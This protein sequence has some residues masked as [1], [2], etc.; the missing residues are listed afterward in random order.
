MI[1]DITDGIRTELMEAQQRHL[2]SFYNLLYLEAMH[3]LVREYRTLVNKCVYSADAV[4]VEGRRDVLGT[5][6]SGSESS[7]E[8]GMVLEDLRRRG[9]E[10]I[11]IVSVDGLSGF[12]ETIEAVYPETIV[13][14]C[15]V[16]KIRNSIRFV[17]HRERRPICTDLRKIYTAANH[18]QALGALEAFKV[19]WGRQGE[20]IGALW[21]KDWD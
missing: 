18:D 1:R 16:H 19:K 10:D 2:H 15:I 13:Q 21:E 20:R 7:N 11:L 4:D 6:I 9:V 8:W 5:Y 17:S 3:F 12:K 14:R